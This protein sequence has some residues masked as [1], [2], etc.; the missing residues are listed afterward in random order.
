MKHNIFFPVQFVVLLW[1]VKLMENF[2]GISFVEFG[3]YPRTIGQDFKGIRGIFFAPLIH[4]NFGHLISNTVPLLI[5]GISLFLFYPKI[6]TRVFIMC[7]LL[8]GLLV[9]LFAVQFSYHI[10]ASGLVYGLAFFLMTIGVF[11]KDFKSLAISI[12]IVFLYG[13]LIWGVLPNWMGVSW[14]SHLSG[15]IVGVVCASYYGKRDIG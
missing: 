11:K 5:L 3:I 15:A 10:G 14:E 4:S 9:W 8:T 7:H 1:G 2:F 13:S 12:G 6:A